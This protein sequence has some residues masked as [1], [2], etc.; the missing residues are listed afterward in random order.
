MLDL[1]RFIPT[2]HF[3]QH[4]GSLETV[5]RASLRQTR[6]GCV[7][8]LRESQQARL[9]SLLRPFRPSSHFWLG[10][11]VTDYPP[12]RHGPPKVVECDRGRSMAPARASPRKP[13]LLQILTKTLQARLPCSYIAQEAKMPPLFSYRSI[14][15]VT[16]RPIDHVALAGRSSQ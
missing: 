8:D 7:N 15:Y 13:A 3:G 11:R 12:A 6:T 9:L 2:T 1:P 10:P 4:L 14:G 16:L 5:S